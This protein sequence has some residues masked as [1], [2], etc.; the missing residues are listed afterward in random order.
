MYIFLDDLRH[1]VDVYP[2][3]KDWT[4]ARDIEFVK[5]FL[6]KGI[7]QVLSLDGDMGKDKE[8]NDT[9]GG[10]QLCDWMA[11]TGHWPQD[12]ILVHSQNPVKRSLML[13]IINQHFTRR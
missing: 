12:K 1:P 7:V 11:K 13:T 10:V 5:P 8:G 3:A 4:I 6:K 9:P 2:Y